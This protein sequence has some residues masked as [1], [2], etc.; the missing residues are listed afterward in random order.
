[1]RMRIQRLLIKNFR[2]FREVS[3]E[4][5][6]GLIVLIGENSSGK[7]NF[8]EALYLFFN[9]FDPAPQR[10]IG[11]VND[12]IWFDRNQDQRIEFQLRIVLAEEELKKILPEQLHAIVK[13]ASDNALEVSRTISGT[14]GAASWSTKWI[15]VND[16]KLVDEGQLVYK[17]EGP[18]APKPQTPGVSPTDLL[19]RLLQSLSQNFKG[20][21]KVISA[22]RNTTG[23]AARLG[24]RVSFIHP[25]TVGEL[26]VFGQSMER[27]HQQ[28]WRE[29][30][31]SVTT[32]ASDIRDLRV[33]AGQITV[34]EGRSAI[35]YPIS[36]VGGGNQEVL[37]LA[38]ELAKDE[39]AII[40]LEE[41]EQHLH[42]E[43]ARRFFDGLKEISKHR[44]IFVTTH[45]P[46]FVDRVELRNTW[47][48]RKEGNAS[49]FV[50][51]ER[52]GDLQ[53]IL[54]ELGTRPSDI[55]FSN[56]VVFVEGQTEAIV[57]P[58]LARKIGIDFRE[59]GLS[60]VPTY[61]KSSGKYHLNV[62]IE[63]SGAAQVPYFVILD[64]DA[65]NEVKK[66]TSKELL[67]PGSNLFILKKGSIEDYYPEGRIMEALKSEFEI[68]ANDAEKGELLRS[69]RAQ[70]I[71]EF[72]R[73]KGKDTTGWKVVLGRK[74]A[75]TMTQEEID[76]EILGVLER[77]KTKRG[78]SSE[79]ARRPW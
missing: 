15:A 26:T 33:I 24:D 50:R 47:I 29:V 40:G 41:P 13:P 60:I 66:L 70:S 75:A 11:A 57:L 20:K 61:G 3:M 32:T 51:I 6:G 22:A 46:I 31:E 53:N 49:E 63:A 56:A 44:Q 36:L 12:Y 35:P 62:W 34:R 16:V 67:K 23:P 14:A 17:L 43:L 28:K 59:I 7:S 5:L 42:P 54:Y 30:E 9:E 52:A 76:E 10:N 18:T 37:T 2:S 19:G 58:T 39:S 55:F 45:S 71:K 8:H 77:L 21:Y 69:P 79:S 27:V 74:I 78:P 64:R 72:L 25:T 73:K 38:H 65:E 4:D 68:E 1:M 48:V